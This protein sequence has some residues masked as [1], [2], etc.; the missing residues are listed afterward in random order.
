MSPEQNESMSVEQNESAL[1][2]SAA[3]NH[4]LAISW[5]KIDVYFQYYGVGDVFDP[6]IKRP[7]EHSEQSSL[8]SS[9]KDDNDPYAGGHMTPTPAAK[10]TLKI[11]TDFHKTSADTS[12]ETPKA[13][14]KDVT[15]DQKATTPAAEASTSKS[16]D[17]HVPKASSSI[18]RSAPIDIPTFARW[19][20]CDCKLGHNKEERNCLGC[21]HICC[22]DCHKQLK[23]AEPNP[24]G[25]Y[26]FGKQYAYS[27]GPEDW[28]RFEGQFW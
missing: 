21:G 26:K 4:F 20:C 7:G 8:S 12:A 13:A 28:E 5:H 23:H 14:L 9:P 11:D 2:C 22:R 15:D 6:Q 24:R 27:V 17:D 18:P 3:L 25:G 16:Q 1:V 10:P 19:I